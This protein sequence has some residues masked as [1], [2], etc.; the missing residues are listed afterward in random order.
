[1][2]CVTPDLCSQTH[3]LVALSW[4][5]RLCSLA[6]CSCLKSDYTTSSRH[7]QVFL[8]FSQFSASP[9]SALTLQQVVLPL[10]TILYTRTHNVRRRIRPRPRA[11]RGNGLRP[12]PTSPSAQTPDHPAHTTTP[13]SSPS[14]NIHHRSENRPTHTPSHL[15]T[16]RRL[17]NPRQPPS[18]RE[19][20]HL[21]PQISTLGVFRQLT[22]RLCARPNN[23]RTLSFSE[24]PPTPPRI[25]IQTDLR[26]TRAIPPPHYS[27][28]GGYSQPRRNPQGTE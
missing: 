2:A 19:S 21:T 26:P 10:L 15:Q 23:M 8:H 5:H 13:R 4:Q 22:S 7:P 27:C 20:H 25:H 12:N 9:T 1:M 16:H 18:K 14:S 24:V 11:P 3:F 28:A 17:I 6:G